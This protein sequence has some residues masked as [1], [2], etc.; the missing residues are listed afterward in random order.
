MRSPYCNILLAAGLISAP[1]IVNAV[2]PEI[3]SVNL[4]GSG[5]TFPL[6]VYQTWATVYPFAQSNV[7]RPV[8]LS[9]KYE[10][11]GSGKG[12]ALITDRNVTFGASDS[13]IS[14]A[15][16]AKAGGKLRAVPLLAGSVVV[17]YNLPGWSNA[18]DGR[19]VLTQGA[20]VGI[21]NGVITSW[22]D[23]LLVAANPKLQTKYD[24]KTW[25]GPTPVISTGI[26]AESS[27]TT[28]IFTR[29]LSSFSSTWNSSYGFFSSPTAWPK[30]LLNS[31]TTFNA[32][33]NN[34]LCIKV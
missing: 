6:V 27:G 31:T 24:P 10:G 15:E 29:G 12:K 17:T 2:T 7:F 34:G 13:A 4:T 25:T 16:L 28:E 8:N 11:T 20:L 19:L 18:V 21:F 32:T 9:L 23:P 22:L 3:V 33:G 1:G 26:R 5:A 30:A 14:D